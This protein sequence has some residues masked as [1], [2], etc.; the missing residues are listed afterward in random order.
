MGR[1]LTGKWKW[2]DVI[3]P[4]DA[5]DRQMQHDLWVKSGFTSNGQKFDS[6]RFTYDETWKLEY[7]TGSIFVMTGAGYSEEDYATP[8]EQYRVIDFGTGSEA[9]DDSDGTFVAWFLSNVTRYGTVA[10]KLVQIAENEKAVYQSGYDKALEEGGYNGGFEAGKKEE[11]DASWE[12]FQNSGNRNE[13][14]YAFA[15]QDTET[16]HPK[17]KVVPKTKGGAYRM[18]YYNKSVKKLESAHF[19]LSN[20]PRGTDG[21]TSYYYLCANCTAL[22]EVEDIGLSPCYGYSYAFYRCEN[23]RKVAKITVD[24]DTILGSVI[25]ENCAKLEE[26][27]F[28]GEIGRALHIGYSPLLK[29]ECIENIFSHLSDN[30]SNT[31]TLSKVAVDEAFAWYVG[32]S[33]IPGTDSAEWIELA[34]SKPNWTI[35]LV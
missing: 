29:R 15:F 23:L 1:V 27:Y 31:L 24:K 2:N 9:D 7:G 34:A 21:S 33:K 12:A 17:Y 35:T 19:D 10:E 8:F 28:E 3:N 20:M 18:F 13:Y 16:I 11:R 5:G 26:V 22:E 4:M 32:E 30:V 14:Q 6:I 25:F